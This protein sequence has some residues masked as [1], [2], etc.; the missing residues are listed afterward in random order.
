MADNHTPYTRNVER[1]LD[2]RLY[3]IGH[4]SMI[5]LA[6]SDTTLAIKPEDLSAAHQTLYEVIFRLSGE[7]VEMHE[8]AE[9]RQ[10]GGVE[11]SSTPDMHERAEKWP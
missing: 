4:L 5:G 6:A 2:D 8:R 9:K 1:G 11:N 3:E 10:H 7:A